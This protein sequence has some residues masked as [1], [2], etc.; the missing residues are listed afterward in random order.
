M[1]SIRTYQGI[2]PQLGQRVYIDEQSTVIGDVILGDDCSVWPHATIRG[3][4]HRIRLGNGC[5]V[6]DNACL[7]I[8][9]TSEYNPKGHPLNIGN[10]VTIGHSAILHGCTVGSRV[11]VG[12]GAVIL[13]GAIVEND[14][15]IAASTLVTPNQ[16]LAS[17]YLYKGSPAVKARPLSDREIGQLRYGAENYIRLKNTFLGLADHEWLKPNH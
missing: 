10:L 9:H 6:Q 7:H 16:H 5:S 12:I 8:T 4:M 13:D 3:D 17:G 2:T 14:V 1:N 15:L 11:L